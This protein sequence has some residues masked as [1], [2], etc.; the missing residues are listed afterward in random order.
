MLPP[1]AEILEEI[2]QLLAENDP[3]AD[4]D[5]LRTKLHEPLDRIY[6][7]DSQIGVDIATQLAEK[8]RLTS[9]PRTKLRQRSDYIS[10][11]GLFDHIK[12]RSLH[13]Q[14]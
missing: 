2:I 14:S 8:Y 9:V 1:D 10:I 11:K 12:R 3:D 7:I 4:P 5:V 6:A 13:Q